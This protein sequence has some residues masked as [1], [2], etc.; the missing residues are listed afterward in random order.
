MEFSFT[1]SILRVLLSF[2]SLVLSFVMKL[3]VPMLVFLMSVLHCIGLSIPVVVIFSIIVFTM[4]SMLAVSSRVLLALVLLHAFVWFHHFM[5]LTGL[6]SWFAMATLSIP[7][8]EGTG[9]TKVMTIVVL[10]Y[11]SLRTFMLSIGRG[12][13]SSSSGASGENTDD[14]SN[15]L[16]R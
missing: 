7:P 3:L 13:R 12:T 16:H 1:F 15:A 11:C 4:L 5:M 2:K 10:P 14:E 8:S 6:V 9:W